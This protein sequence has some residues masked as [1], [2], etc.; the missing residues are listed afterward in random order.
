MA[1]GS[2]AGNPASWTTKASMV[3][4]EQPAGVGFSYT[5]NNAELKSNDNQVQ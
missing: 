4:L 1:D 3:F 5:T 2:L